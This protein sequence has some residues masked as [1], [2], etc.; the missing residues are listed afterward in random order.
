MQGMVQVYSTVTAHLTAFKATATDNTMQFN[1][2]TLGGT[3]GDWYELTD[4][5][6]GFWQVNGLTA[7]TG[8][9]VTPFLTV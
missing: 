4:V 5:K 8:S 2:S 7:P 1:G 6:T 3:L 9:E